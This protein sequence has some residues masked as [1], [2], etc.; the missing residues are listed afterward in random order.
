M[1]RNG[2]Q[3]LCKLTDGRNQKVLD[4]LTCQNDRGVLFAHTLHA[5]AQIFDCSHIR[6]KEVQ[7]VHRCRRAAFAEQFVAHERQNIEQHT[8]L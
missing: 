7:L 1:R 4:I 6:E 8:V 2:K 5:V 3:R